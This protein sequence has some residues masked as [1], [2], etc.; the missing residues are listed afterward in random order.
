[1]V[2][3]AETFRFRSTPRSALFTARSLGNAC[4]TCGS[5]TTTLV[6]SATFRA[7]LPRTS[8]P[9]SE[10]LYSGRSSSVGLRSAFFIDIPLTRSCGACTDNSD[11]I[12]AF[13]MSYHKQTPACR[14]AEGD[15]PLFANC[16]IG[17]LA[18][19]LDSVAE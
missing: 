17:V 9:K 15:E 13:G 16:V 6:A 3:R 14:D 7:Y 12:A 18:G 10:R 19:L 11:C 5:S 4:A 8:V 2:G 1:M